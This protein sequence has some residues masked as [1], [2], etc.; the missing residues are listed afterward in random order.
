[1]KWWGEV[2]FDSTLRWQCLEIFLVVRTRG[3][4]L[5]SGEGGQR[6]KVLFK[7]TTVYRTA[8]LPVAHNKDLS[9]PK[10]QQRQQIQRDDYFL[11]RSKVKL[12]VNVKLSGISYTFFLFPVKSESHFSVWSSGSTQRLNE[13]PMVFS[14]NFR[15]KLLKAV[16]SQGQCYTFWENHFQFL[17]CRNQ[18]NERQGLFCK[19]PRKR[20]TE[21]TTYLSYIPSQLWGDFPVNIMQVLLERMGFFQPSLLC[22]HIIIPQD[23]SGSTI[24]I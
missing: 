2:D 21:K 23:K 20:K 12:S 6:L 11:G 5:A 1:M 22:P 14:L 16:C 3:M 10:S 15:S 13:A 24:G 19:Q 4:L 9:S 8:S 17:S 18:R 7:Y